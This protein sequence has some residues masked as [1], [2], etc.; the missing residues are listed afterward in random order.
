MRKVLLFLPIL[1]MASLASFA[2]QD[3]GRS[4][5][6]MRTLLGPDTEHGFFLAGSMMAS[7]FDGN[8]GLLAGG[9]LGWVIDHWFTFGLAGY[10]LTNPIY[11][12]DLNDQN[13]NRN[14]GLGYGGLYFEPRL[15]S[16]AAV[17]VA[18]PI[19]MGSGGASF[20]SSSEYYYNNVSGEWEQYQQESDAFFFVEPGIELEVNISRYFRIGLAGTYRMVDG[21]NLTQLDPNALN[22]FS[23]GVNLKVGA[24]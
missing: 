24:F 11:I 19:I 9:K 20:S 2:Q 6:Q 14:I 15:F 4:P 8:D 16:E 12:E 18:F 7:E 3:E 21:L 5:Y 13:V 23:G 22:G 17:H 10:G 1:L